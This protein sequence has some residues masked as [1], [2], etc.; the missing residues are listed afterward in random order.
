MYRVVVRRMLR[1]GEAVGARRAEA[2]EFTL[3]ALRNGKMDA[4]QSD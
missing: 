1:V 2:G 3:R 4:L